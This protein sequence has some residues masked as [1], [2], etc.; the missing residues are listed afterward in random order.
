MSH[1]TDQHTIVPV[2]LL[3]IDRWV[4]C[5]Y[6]IDE[7]GTIDRAEFIA[8]IKKLTP[9]I[10]DHASKMFDSFDTNQD[11]ILSFDEFF[12]VLPI[13]VANA[14][15]AVPLVPPVLV[16]LCC[17]CCASGAA[18]AAG[19]M[20]LVLLVLCLWCRQCCWCYAA[21]GAGAV[22]LVLPV[23]LVLCC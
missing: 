5:R 3:C 15:C 17:L 4:V 22:P 7:D 11:G 19:A 1:T 10:A 9:S 13:T 21:S 20:P 23:L 8:A 16:V 2:R 6:D 14:A 12:A 18:S